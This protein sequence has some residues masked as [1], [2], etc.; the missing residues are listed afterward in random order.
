MGFLI[1][2]FAL[3]ASAEAKVFLHVDEAMKLALPD[4]Q[5]DRETHF[6]TEDQKS[7]AAET[8]GSKVDSAMVVRYVG[9]CP[10]KSGAG[11]PPTRKVVY[12]D[13][14][15]VR[16]KPETILVL[17]EPAVKPQDE[18]IVSRVEVL[19]FDE[20]LEY[21]PKTNWYLTYQGKK[22][23]PRLQIRQDIPLITG[24]TLTAQATTEAVR[25]ILALE[26]TLGHGK[27]K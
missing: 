16:T 3:I 26:K 19:S 18:P 17:L 20:P 27:P 14:H 5:V 8:S 4:C 6:L 24:S 15:R 25:K 1:S 22:L 23:E 9:T 2:L 10:A 11:A 7:K 13:A 12:F 21:I